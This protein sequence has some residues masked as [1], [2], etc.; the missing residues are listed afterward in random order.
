[1]NLRGEAPIQQ[2]GKGLARGWENHQTTTQVGPQ[3][4]KRK[5][6]WLERP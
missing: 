5:E 2:N 1:M 3:V 6:D 4:K